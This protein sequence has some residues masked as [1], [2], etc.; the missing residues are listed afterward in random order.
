MNRL[1]DLSVVDSIVDAADAPELYGA[2]GMATT[3]INGKR[4]IYVAGYYDDGIQILR[5]TNK[6]K[7]VPEGS[8]AWTATNGLD[9]PNDLSIASVAGKKYLVAVNTNAH[10]M[11][12]FRID[13]EKKG[14]DGDL[15][16]T[17][18]VFRDSVTGNTNSLYQPYNLEQIQIGNKVFFANTAFTGDA[19]AVFQ[20][21]GKGKLSFKDAVY[22][23]QNQKFE[24]DGADEIDY[25]KVG[26]KHLLFVTGYYDQGF[27]VWS[28]NGKGQLKAVDNKH[29]GE[30]PISVLATDFNGQKLLFVSTYSNKLQT[31][32]VQNT[33]KV[34]LLTEMSQADIGTNDIQDLK[35]ITL[36]G[37]DYLVGLGYYDTLDVLSVDPDG[38]VS[39]VQSIVDSTI[40]DGQGD[41]LQINIGGRYF[42]VSSHTNDSNVTVTEIGAG[43]DAL[44]GTN[45]DDRMSGLNGNDDLIGR[46]G[47]D[48]LVGG[49]GDDVL[50]GGRNNDVLK[51]GAGN[52]ILVG[53]L[54]NDTLNGGS[55]ADVMV[56]GGGIDTLDYSS[57]GG[58]VV[59]DLAKGTAKG[60]EATGDTFVGFENIT[61]GKKGDLLKGD[62]QKNTLKGGNG[63]DSLNGA[64]GNDKLLG[65]NDNDTLKGGSGNDLLDGGEGKDKLFGEDGN[66]KL[67]GGGGNDLLDGGSG[68]DNLD[69]GSGNDKL[70]GGAGNDTMNG[71]GG[72]DTFVFSGNFGDDTIKG[73]DLAND[74]VDLSAIS[75]VTNLNQFKASAITIA[76]TA[77]LSVGN[78]SVAF[79]NVHENDFS[80]D[81]FIFT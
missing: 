16:H 63:N 18:S 22:D 56:G 2:S 17:D 8:V 59:I 32:K 58:R 70:I 74:I 72:V 78:S 81:N 24:L 21:N 35:K 44:M 73:F 62:G 69:G 15:I 68:N 19:L 27:G 79:E 54:H 25:L 77:Y 1:G 76:G 13:D 4:F 48:L 57:A 5:M 29:I 52:D 12:V 39:S 28:V 80:G 20:L 66:D 55:G 41:V 43:E 9:A 61:G 64:G 31:W 46:A 38:T 42:F 50:S 37:V 36:D 65:Q 47:N 23:G 33:G 10:S 3:V 40:F 26:S 30:Y 14:T 49:K 75:Q 11:S 7:L 67:I 45:K 6:G 60:S 51:G 71:G 34:K 53:G